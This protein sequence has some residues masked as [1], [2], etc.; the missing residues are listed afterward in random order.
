[1]HT[2]TLITGLVLWAALLFS[3]A[4]HAQVAYGGEPTSLQNDKVNWHIPVH[5]MPSFDLEAMLAEDEVSHEFKD[6]P[7]RFGKNFYLGYNLSNSGQWHTLPNGDR[8][9]LLGIESYGAYSLNLTFDMFDI[10][11]G[12]HMYV[13]K[14][15]GSEF[16]GKFDHRNNNADQV[17]STWPV[18]GESLVIELYEPAEAI[19]QSLLQVECVTH[20]Y[21]DL[22]KVARDIGDSGSCN[23][24]VVCAVGDPWQN[25]I[26][27]VAM[28]VVGSNG[29]C[30]GSLINNVASDGHPY[31]LTANH[32]TGGGVTN[33]VFRFNWQSITCVGN[34]AD[35]YQTVTGSTLLASG[36]SADYALLEINNGNPVPPAYNPYYAGWDAT[37]VN[38]SSQVGVHH[39][40]GDLKK[41]SFDNQ[42]AG[43]ASWGGASCWQIFTWEDGTTEPGS[44]GSPLF[45][46][47]HRIIGQ[48]YGGQAQCSNNV[49]DY[50]GKFSVT[51]PNICSWIDPGCTAGEIDGYDPNA[52][53]VALDAELQS[54]SAP[55]GTICGET[56]DALVILR[57]AGSTTLT[58]VDIIWDVDGG[59]SSTYAWS[60]SLITGAT[61]VVNLGS[62]TTSAGA[63]AFNAAVDDPNGGTDENAANDDA[64]SA[65]TTQLGG[66][67]V[68]VEV[69]TDCWGE[70][71]SWDI[72]DG[73]GVVFSVAENTLGDLVTVSW[74]VCLSAG[75]Y[76]FN[77][78][79]AYGDGMYGTQWGCANNGSYTLDDE[80]G[81]NLVTMTATNSDYGFGT[82]HNF[83]VPVGV[84]GCMDT[85][86]CKL[87]QRS[88]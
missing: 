50:Y 71:V 65:F 58:S 34:T 16:I 48:L 23:N 10:P 56:Y 52:A 46:Q 17:F 67:M 78:N 6:A 68:T 25:E 1:M 53:T 39:P 74:D 2:R 61:T 11:E 9:W 24:N 27:S 29:I 3:A 88:N 66:T 82:T 45:D 13:Y 4:S 40:S 69:S 22:D 73:G 35:A 84:P 57:N 33:W 75:C 51:Y 47:D 62:V 42:A 26:N 18:P 80:N 28:I 30:T 14:A 43:S 87:R 83:C 79:D 63:H 64:S 81:N 8:V 7:F 36:A 21:R 85:T 20:A 44:S 54:I 59:A 12:G 77:I 76:D 32:C 55:T 41:I 37:G 38:P 5:S 60:G 49:N 70:E 72:S 19:G 31:F 86:A 15:D